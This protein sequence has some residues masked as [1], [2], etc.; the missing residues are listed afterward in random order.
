MRQTPFKEAEPETPTQEFEGVP[1][2]NREPFRENREPASD[3][4][5]APET[6]ELGGDAHTA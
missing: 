4:T 3:N 5:Q 1:W 2:E 6:I